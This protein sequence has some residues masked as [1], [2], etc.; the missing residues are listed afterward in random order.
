MKC[1]ADGSRWQRMAG[2]KEKLTW[3]QEKA[4]L[5][6]LTQP[7]PDQAARTVGVG[8]RTLYRWLKEPEFDAAYREARR[9]AFS[10]S[11]A[12]LQHASSAAATTLLKLAVDTNTPASTRARAA[13]AV[14]ALGA[15]GIEQ[16]DIEPRLA[17][18][19]AAQKTEPRR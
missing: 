11:I 17:A 8:P 5:A 1:P 7:N 16:E 18:L 14:I 4:I 9:T 2:S 15:K 13:I 19:E 6:L 12:R 3:K 10:Q